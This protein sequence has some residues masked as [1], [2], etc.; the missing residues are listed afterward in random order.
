[1]AKVP[2]DI[3]QWHSSCLARYILS[4]PWAPAGMLSIAMEVMRDRDA[5]HA[6]ELCLFYFNPTYSHRVHADTPPEILAE[7]KR[8]ASLPS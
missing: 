4:Q 1:M 8:R 2:P 5:T 3:S 6:K 7:L